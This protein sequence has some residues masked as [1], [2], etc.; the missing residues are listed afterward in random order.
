MT[1]EFASGSVS[2]RVPHGEGSPTCGLRRAEDGF[3]SGLQLRALLHSNHGMRT[4][5]L[6][7]DII[8]FPQPLET[9]P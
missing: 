2:L 9:S 8:P 5:P 1:S 3:A 4:I 6:P 7:G